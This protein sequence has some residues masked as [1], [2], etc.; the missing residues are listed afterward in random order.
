L[1]I[2]RAIATCALLLASA[3]AFARFDAS[4]DSTVISEADTLRLT[5]RT[6]G[7]NVSGDPDLDALTDSF[8]VLSTQRSSEFRSINGRV[9]G[10]TTWTLLL[11]PK[12]TGKVEIPTIAFGDQKSAPIDVTV[13]E[14]DPQL[15]RAIAQ[16]VFFET[17]YEPKQVYVQ[18]QVVVTRRLFYLN[19]AQLYGDMPNV[20]DVPGA[21]V[22]ALGESEHTTAQ[23]EGR[24]YGMIEQRFSVFPE[25]S[26]DLAIPP[27]SVTGSVRLATDA[28]GGGRRIGVDVTSDPLTIRVL[29]IPDDYPRDAAW[30]PATD[31]ELLEDWPYDPR[32]G[33]ATGT[34]T[35]RTLIVRVDGNAAS[36]IPPLNVQLPT[37][38]KAYPEQ[39]KL[40]ETQTATGI[41]GTRTESSS[42][43]ATQPGDLTLAEVRL[44]WWDVVHRALKMATLSARTIQV[45]GAPIP[46]APPIADKTPKPQEASQ[47]HLPTGANESVLPRSTLELW[48]GIVL[49]AV[50]L[51]VAVTLVRGWRRIGSGSATRRAIDDEPS[52]FKTFAHACAGNDAHAIRLALDAWLKA[53]YGG[54]IEAATREFTRE[55]A[56]RVAIDQLNAHLYQRAEGVRFSATEL[57]RCVDG[58]RKRRAKPAAADE[59]PALYPS[60]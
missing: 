9:D 6:D 54:S 36:A 57:K 45:T 35:Q 11:K 34:P 58:A 26:G 1:V 43:V 24:Q 55:S 56:A 52:A 33:L 16:T 29:P 39:P 48:L 14:L 41:V 51:G 46:S 3:V 50:L 7:A 37:S 44:P 53:R 4:V 30:L 25:R 27:A 2:R 60:A 20:P 42:L 19:G 38:L 12:R 13:R 15:K 23:R 21:M 10:S 40:S 8:D 5:L 28:F 17:T 32:T 31:V 47:P 59:L 18:A 49:A 22:K